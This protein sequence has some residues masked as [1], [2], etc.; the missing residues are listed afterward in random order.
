MHL[1]VI[2][3]SFQIETKK[4]VNAGLKGDSSGSK[5]TSPVAGASVS[6]IGF[7]SPVESYGRNP[8]RG[9]DDLQTIGGHF[10]LQPCGTHISPTRAP[11]WR[12]GLDARTTAGYDLTGMYS[13]LCSKREMTILCAMC[14][15]TH[16]HTHMHI[17]ICKEREREM[18][19]LKWDVLFY[20]KNR[21]WRKS[22]S[23]KWRLRPYGRLEN[24]FEGTKILFCRRYI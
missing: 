11:E 20:R 14:R 4:D 3:G 24:V 19:R 17:Y 16:I 5:L 12:G 8:V 2:V 18:K 10:M 13:P 9:N 7:R 22:I 1:Q 15:G 6:S 21:W 23:G